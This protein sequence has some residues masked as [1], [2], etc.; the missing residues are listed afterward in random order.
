MLKSDLVFTELVQLVKPYKTRRKVI[1]CVCMVYPDFAP[2]FYEGFY[3]FTSSTSSVNT[4]LDFAPGLYGF[5][6]CTIAL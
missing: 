2:G 6:I 4:S 5:M 1:L 3:G